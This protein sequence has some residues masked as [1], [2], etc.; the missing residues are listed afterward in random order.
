MTQNKKEIVSEKTELMAKIQ[1]HKEERN[2]RFLP[3]FLWT[4]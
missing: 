1:E 4:D 3:I 2:E